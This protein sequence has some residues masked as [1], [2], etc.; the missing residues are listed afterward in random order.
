MAN[1]RAVVISPVIHRDK[2]AAR[3]AGVYNVC[4]YSQ[5]EVT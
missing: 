4:K 1:S 2:A 5:S 3:T